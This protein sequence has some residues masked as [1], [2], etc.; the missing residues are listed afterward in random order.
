[1][2]LNNCISEFSKKSEG[3]SSR[4]ALRAARP[5]QFFCLAE[6]NK[7]NNKTHLWF[8]HV[9]HHLNM[10]FLFKKKKNTPGVVTQLKQKI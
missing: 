3:S 7:K 4:C 9:K 8:A 1:M 10:F 2:N 5:L 6:E